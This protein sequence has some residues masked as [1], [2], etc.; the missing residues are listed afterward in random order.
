[1]N[2]LT[3][4][5]LSLILTV[6]I[7]LHYRS[8]TQGLIVPK[9]RSATA[10]PSVALRDDAGDETSL[11]GESPERLPTQL[12][13]ELMPK[14]VAVIMDGNGRCAKLRGL[15][16]S[17]GHRAGG[18]SL[19]RL[20]RLCCSWGI[21]VPTVFAFST[22]NWVRFKV[23]HVFSFPSAFS[24][25]SYCFAEYYLWWCCAGE[26]DFLMRLC[27]RTIN[28]AVE[29][30]KKKEIRISM[31]GESSKMLESLQRMTVSAEENTKHNSRLQLTVAISYGGKF[32]VVQACKNVA[33][34]V[35]DGLVH[36]DDINDSIIKQELETNCTKFPYPDLLIRAGTSLECVTSCCDN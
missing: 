8:Q 11:D 16:P 25:H 5:P 30:M 15:P 3:P 10:P 12:V 22:D 26:V 24:W 13:A 28:S 36:L 31:I 1:M 4:P 21:K 14:H 20:V 18:Q 23:I 19:T 27:E 35:K 29:C 32:N 9:R 2:T 33:K 34:K 6:I 7:I 17:A